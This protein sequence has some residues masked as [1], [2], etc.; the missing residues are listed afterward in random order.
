M[1]LKGDLSSEKKRAGDFQMLGGDWKLRQ[2]LPSCLHFFWE[3]EW[4]M[5]A[6]A[7]MCKDC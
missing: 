3:A 1:D 5:V 4:G 2:F 7:A 6:E